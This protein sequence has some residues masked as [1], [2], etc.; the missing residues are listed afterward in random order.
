VIAIFSFKH[1][2][3]IML[4]LV[5]ITKVFKTE[6]MAQPFTALKSVSF[7]VP[8]GSMVG[9][10]GAN[11]AGK[12]T[13]LKI[14]M[15]FIRP[16]SGSI[17]FDPKLGSDR[18]QIFSKIGF[19]PERPY[20]Y[21]N[22]TGFEFLTYMGL[23]SELQPHDIRA[24]IAKWAPRFKID[25]ALERTLKT[26][27]KGM[28]QRTGFL[29]TILHEPDFIILDEPL[30]GLDP[31][32]RKELKDVIVEVHAEGKTVFFSSHIVPD[33]EEIC[34]RVIFLQEGSLVYDGPVDRLLTTNASLNYLIKFRSEGELQLTSGH[35]SF[36]HL[37]GGIN[38]CVVSEGQK[39]KL[40]GELL[41][42]GAE[43]NGVELIKPSLEEIFYKIKRDQ[44]VS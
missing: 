2:D 23:L 12:T 8:E 22:L 21:P 20:F 4:K 39:N 14:I 25:H 41:Q 9:F 17:I 30:S 36:R 10:L 32:G 34:D 24:R 44:H 33:I 3:F 11:G 18:N 16:D 42:V 5:D 19:L 40:L 15:D 1:H 27:S 43:I 6:L 37:A 26:Y 31:I 7:E 29:A 35:S 13:S 38:S 28:L